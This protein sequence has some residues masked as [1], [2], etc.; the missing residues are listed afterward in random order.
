MSIWTAFQDFIFWGID[1][2][3]N[4]IGDW[5]MA[6]VLVTILFR[7]IIWPLMNS[8]VKS[9]YQMQ[10]MQ[11]LMQ[12][13]QTKYA[14]DPQRMQQE[15][16][17][18]YAEAHFNPISGCLPL[19]LQMPIFIALF[20][21][22]QQMGDRTSGTNYEFYHLIPDLTLS[23]AS[24]FSQGILIFLPY[25]ILLLI[26]AFTTFLPTLIMQR[27]T[28]NEQQRKQTLIMTL[29]MSLFML[30]IGWGSPAGVLLFWSTSSIL[31][32]I[33]TQTGTRRM[34]RLDAEK[35][36]IIEDKPVEV[37]VVRREHKKRPTKK[38]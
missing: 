30:W 17:K 10:K 12:E 34:K 19:L 26:F 16:Q 32:L 37:D 2:V 3:Y 35:E 27:G 18:I 36:A 21:V 38:H 14:D 5:G 23:P 15:M 11:P 20:Q 6:I 29:I 4:V 13:V 8:Q 24:T 31:G 25:I 22:L 1:V 7:L 33:Q 28:A 9:S